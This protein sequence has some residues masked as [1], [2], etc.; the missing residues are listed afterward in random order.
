MRVLAGDIGGTN[1][2][3]AIVVV[4][5]GRARIEREQR[6]A[7]QEAPSLASIVQRFIGDAERSLEWACFGVAGRVIDGGAGK[8]GR[9]SC[10]ER[11]SFLV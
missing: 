9:A 2:R 6:S 4:E 10:R 3:L 7:S 5:G 11:V 8:I 1:A